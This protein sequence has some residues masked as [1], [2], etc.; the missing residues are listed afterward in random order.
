MAVRRRKQQTQAENDAS[1]D[2]LDEDL[3]S[4]LVTPEEGMRM[5]DEEARRRLGISGEEFLRRWDAGEYLPEP[6]DHPGVMG[7]WLLMPFAGRV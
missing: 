7:L 3:K 6:D 1:V 2:G 4:F 5:F